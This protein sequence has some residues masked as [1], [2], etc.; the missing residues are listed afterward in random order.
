MGPFREVVEQ[1]DIDWL[2][3]TDQ[4]SGLRIRGRVD[5]VQGISDG[6]LQVIDYKTADRD[7]TIRTFLSTKRG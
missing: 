7:T 1:L 5:D 6:T 2:L 4:A 3:H